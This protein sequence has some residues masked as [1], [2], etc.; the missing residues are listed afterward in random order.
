VI[1]DFTVNHAF[2]SNNM[3][4]LSQNGIKFVPVLIRN[5]NG[6]NLIADFTVC[7]RIICR[8][9]DTFHC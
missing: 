7:V 8:M 1:V 9:F 2:S 5:L 3:A 6:G 4:C